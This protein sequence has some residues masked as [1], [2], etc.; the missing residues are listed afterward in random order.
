MMNFDLFKEQIVNALQ[1]IFEDT[2]VSVTSVEKNNGVILDG[3]LFFNP[4]KNLSPTI[5]ING[6]YEQY[7]DGQ[8]LEDIV[9]TIAKIYRDNLPEKNFDVTFYTDWQRVKH[10]IVYCLVNYEKNADLLKNVPHFRFLDC[11]IVFRCLAKCDIYGTATILVK[12]EHLKFWNID[13]D[14]LHDVAMINTP[15]LLPAEI[16]NIMDI[17]KDMDVV[18]EDMSEAIGREFPMYVLTN[19]SKL[20]GSAC[21][22]YK[23]ILKDLAIKTNSNLYLLPSS[24]H[25][26]IIIPTNTYSEDRDALKE[27]VASVNSTMLITEEILSDSVYLYDRKNSEIVML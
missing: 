9:E 4:Q 14:E 27:M 5:Y 12:N 2:K 19:Q 26:I 18:D 3:I 10:N 15:E 22:L 23:N 25:E 21:I 7:L 6:Y 8:K 17:L 1:I 16:S 20:N 24:I 13:T 11:A